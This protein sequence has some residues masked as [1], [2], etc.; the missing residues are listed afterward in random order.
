MEQ[1]KSQTQMEQYIRQLEMEVKQL[2]NI[3][4]VIPI[5]QENYNKMNSELL[6]LNTKSKIFEM[7]CANCQN[8]TVQITGST[9]RQNETEHLAKVL[10][11]TQSKVDMLISN[12][13]ARK[14]DFLALYNLTLNN[15]NKLAKFVTE[16]QH[17]EQELLNGTD[18]R[19][20]NLSVVVSVTDN[21]TNR[22]LMSMQNQLA[23]QSER[24]QNLSLVV[25]VTD[26]RTNKSLMSMQN[27]VARQSEKVAVTACADGGHVKGVIIFTNTKESYGINN[28]SPLYYTGRFTCEKPGLYLTV[29]TMM[30][31]T[32]NSEYQIRKNGIAL[33]YVR[34][35]AN[36][37]DSRKDHFHSGTGSAVSIM[38]Q[39]DTFDIYVVNDTFIHPGYSCVSIIKVH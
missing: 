30:S 21:R 28:L 22:S 39:N 23:R 37:T 19:I 35:V 12:D 38:N 33:V 26:N 8:S 1:R 6:Q 10:Q 34:I 3:T 5:I 15:Q 4:S 17:R 20:Q 9:N 25:S 16:S 18:E 32:P 2:V 24:I 11:K 7:Y 14:Q 27:H 36:F 13:K 29:A 31:H